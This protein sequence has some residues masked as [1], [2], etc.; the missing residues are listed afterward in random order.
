[1]TKVEYEINCMV[2][3]EVYRRIIQNERALSGLSEY[4]IQREK[5]LLEAEEISKLGSLEKILAHF[6]N[7][8]KQNG[9]R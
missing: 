6:T 3:M 2:A 4:F 7:Q 5:D 1:M 8:E 9:P